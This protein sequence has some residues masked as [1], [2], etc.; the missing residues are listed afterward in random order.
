[1]NLLNVH[2]NDKYY[3]LKLVLVLTG[4]L[5]LVSIQPNMAFGEGEE[6]CG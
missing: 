1:M 2:Q 5:V 4:T 3:V 6:D